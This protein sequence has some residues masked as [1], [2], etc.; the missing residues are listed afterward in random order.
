MV[1]KAPV[2]G[3]GVERVAQQVVH[4]VGPEG[5]ADDHFGE[6]AVQWGEVKP[7][8]KLLHLLGA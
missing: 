4:P 8:A 6:N 3:A 7:E 1:I 5:V 2:D